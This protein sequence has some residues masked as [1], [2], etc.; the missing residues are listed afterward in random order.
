MMDFWGQRACRGQEVSTP[1]AVAGLRPSG[2]PIINVEGGCASGSL[3]FHEAW[4]PVL[5]WIDDVTIAIGAEK[6]NDP[7]RPASEALD[8]IGAGAGSLDPDACWA[9]YH[10]LAADLRTTC[11]C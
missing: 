2:L 10:E 4:K 3:A 5:A 8:W 6:V 9:R 7:T 11:S 1:L